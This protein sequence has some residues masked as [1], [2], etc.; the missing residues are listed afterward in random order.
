MI[1]PGTR[2]GELVLLEAHKEDH[3]RDIRDCLA[4]ARRVCW[5]P[6]AR[7]A[8][9][10]I[11]DKCLVCRRLEP[12]TGGQSMGMFPTFKMPA[13]SPFTAFGVD[14]MC[15]YLVHEERSRKVVYKVWATCYTC[16]SSKVC[17]FVL[18]A[19]YSAEAFFRAHG[20]FTNT[21]GT[22]STCVVD[23]G[24][25]ILAAAFRPDWQQVA[26]AAGMKGTRWL[27]T[28]KGAPWHAGQAERHIG[29]CKKILNRLLK[30]RTLSGTFEELE[31][32]LARCAWLLNSRPLGVRS[33][34]D[35][36]FILL[37]PNNVLLGKASLTKPLAPE[38]E[39]LENVTFLAALTHMENVARAIF[40]AMVK[41]TF[42]EMVP[43]PKWRW[44]E[45]NVRVGDPGFLS[46]PSK[47][48]R[49]W[50]RPCRVLKVHPDLKVRTVTVS[51]R[52]RRGTAA[53][54]GKEYVPTRLK[55]M[56]ISVQRLAIMLPV[57]EQTEHEEME[58]AQGAARIAGQEVQLASP[59][60]MNPGEEEFQ[61]VAA[62]V[63]KAVEA[64]ATA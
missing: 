12:K 9:Q 8:A 38:P 14:L 34:T 63:L 57:E 5:I 62:E 52:Q 33:F 2:L 51:F 45:R 4:R 56:V 40:Q 29:M 19:G 61:L 11:I 50:F 30:G 60:R 64:A 27:V 25:N 7:Q 47:F 58:K 23:H 26:A 21:Y 55:T 48:S 53:G 39:D 18:L 20:R 37:S 10:R 17:I 13:C 41:E 28:P 59:D 36:D 49:P 22:P 32:L 24:S 1:I 16:F 42:T 6:Q 43:R 46:Y 31:A 54:T 35:S 3:R 44:Q 15:P